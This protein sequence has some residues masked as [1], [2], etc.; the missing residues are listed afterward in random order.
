MQKD[1]LRGKA[2]GNV[3]HKG[4]WENAMNAQAKRMGVIVDR[5][6]PVEEQCLKC[7]SCELMDTSS[8]VE[9]EDMPTYIDSAAEEIT[10]IMEP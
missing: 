1:M 8:T 6:G 9:I 5:F 3:Q 4:D 7:G 2:C 10:R